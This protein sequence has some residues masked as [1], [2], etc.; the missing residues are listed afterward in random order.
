M[1]QNLSTVAVI[2]I[3][4]GKNSFHVLGQDVDGVI[5]LRQKWSRGQVEARLA[6][7]AVPDRHGGSKADKAAAKRLMQDAQRLGRKVAPYLPPD[8]VPRQRVV[9]D[10][11]MSEEEWERLCGPSLLEPR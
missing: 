2:G 1:S 7:S 6:I 10:E 3:D 5:V 8:A 11:P 4:I 9:A